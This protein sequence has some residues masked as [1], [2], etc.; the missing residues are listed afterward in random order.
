MAQI[1]KMRGISS[2]SGS[3]VFWQVS[4]IDYDGSEAP[5]SV[6][7]STIV[8]D[9]ISVVSGD[10]AQLHDNTHSPIVLYNFEEGFELVDS[11]GNG[12]DLNSTSGTPIYGELISNIRMV[13]LR[14]A[15][16]RRTTAVSDLAITGA[17]TIEAFVVNNGPVA[18]F[19]NN[20]V[21]SYQ[22]ANSQFW[23]MRLS[24][25][26]LGISYW[27]GS[28]FIISSSNISKSFIPKL[29]HWAITRASD[30]ITYKF[31]IN[32]ILLDTI[33]SP[34]APSGTHDDE[35]LNIGS[36]RASTSNFNGFIGSVK[37]IDGLLSDA[38]IKA[39]FNR[40]LGPVLGLAE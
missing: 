10:Y 4:E 31:Y 21:I 2:L 17:I 12:F 22:S 38:D 29:E 36:N 14:S 39:E 30:G 6:I 23:D 3:Y 1:Y 8:I 19:N 37:V 25:L 18:E 5:E 7:A 9:S 13:N 33:T 35:T 34:G 40:T 15:S 16:I 27:N 26:L 20:I 28:T 11:S 32:G 24:N